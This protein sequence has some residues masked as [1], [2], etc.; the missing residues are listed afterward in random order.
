MLADHFFWS[1]QINLA[2]IPSTVTSV[3]LSSPS[4][5]ARLWFDACHPGTSSML[6]QHRCLD[7]GQPSLSYG[8]KSQNVIAWI[9][10]EKHVTCSG[11][12][13][14]FVSPFAHQVFL[15]RVLFQQHFVGRQGP[16]F[17]QDLRHSASRFV[18]EWASC[19]GNKNIVKA[20][21]WTRYFIQLYK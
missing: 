4:I 15:L 3:A 18:D 10:Q 1:L 16:A 13:N 20:Q 8:R 9:D 12:S 14:A 21:K 11:R 5:L 2:L 7:S 17:K 19:S 6:V